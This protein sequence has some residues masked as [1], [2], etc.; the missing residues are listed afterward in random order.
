MPKYALATGDLVEFEEE[1]VDSI[2]NFLSNYP[3]AV[4]IEETP[5]VDSEDLFGY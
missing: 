3:N 5:E 1:Q 2:N 4:L